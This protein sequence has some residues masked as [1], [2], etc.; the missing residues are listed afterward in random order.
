M[1]STPQRKHGEISKESS[2]LQ[3]SQPRINESLNEED[4]LEKSLKKEGYTS[5]K[6]MLNVIELNEYTHIFDE[7]FIDL[8]MLTSLKEH[9]FS[10]MLSRIGIT[11]WSHQHKIKLM[12]EK[13][14]HKKLD[15]TINDEETVRNAENETSKT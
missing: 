2:T 8:S 14:K 9:E 10:K 15:E 1:T 7:N 5:T 6:E 4:K 12:V 3:T 13:F 11:A